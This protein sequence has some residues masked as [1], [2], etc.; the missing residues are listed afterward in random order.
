MD[1]TELFAIAGCP[2]LH[3]KSPAMFRRAFAAAGMDAVYI[4]LAM[5]NPAETA[6]TIRELGIR[7]ANITSP[8]KE[9][10]I[11]FLDALDSDAASIGAV[12][13]IVNEAGKLTG[14]NTD[15]EGI[16]RTLMINGCDGRKGK[17][18]VVGAGG[19][20]RAAA[21]ACVNTG[22]ETV[23]VNRTFEK[24][25]RIAKDLGCRARPLEELENETARGDTVI[26]CIPDMSGQVRRSISQKGLTVIN[27]R[28]GKNAGPRLCGP[29]ARMIDGHTWLLF[30]G[31]EA[32]RIFTGHEPPLEEMRKALREEER[33]L[34]TGVSIIGFMGSGKSTIGPVLA[35]RLS[36]AHIDVDT[37][38]EERTGRT[39]RDIFRDSG[40]AVFRGHEKKEMKDAF[41]RSPRVIATGGG[42]VLNEEDADAMKAS[43]I[44]VWLFAGLDETLS[45]I[46]TDMSRPLAAVGK[47]DISG[48]FRDRTGA[49]ARASHLLIRTDGASIDEVAERIAD[50]RNNA[51]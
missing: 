16:R 38:I 31:A 45:R 12:N 17:T 35:K 51:F 8:Y 41:G 22:H 2:V 49:Y 6:R 48:L 24:A 3:S 28:Y 21:F 18:V 46:G 29:A 36:M 19:A 15:R 23:I 37:R 39:I 40:E 20:A 43:S 47:E 26:L 27:A 32:F 4:C 13:T 50:E 10:I 11:P 30:Q 34:Q 9:G 33:P 42:S 7:G 14:Y 1:K 5:R 44:V 25:R